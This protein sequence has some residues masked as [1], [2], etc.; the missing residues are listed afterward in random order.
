MMNKKQSPAISIL[1]YALVIPLFAV[2]L[3]FNSCLK[4]DKQHIETDPA[5][6]PEATT[7]ADVSV[8]I[9]DSAFVQTL[10]DAI[11]NELPKDVK[12]Y[13]HVEVMPQF[14]GGDE[15]LRKWLQD[16]IQFPTIA[17][18]KGIQGRVVVRFVVSP[19]GK[20]ENVSIQKSI[21]PACDKEA[22]RVVKTM[23]DWIPGKMGGKGVYVY[24]S[25]PI[26]F[27]STIQ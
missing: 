13:E 22:I 5:T 1:K 4:T 26:N 19:S 20:I 15:A 11:E 6:E 10:N 3:F 25:L 27:K 2:L 9:E 21:D 7:I 8:A 17:A 14:P 24:F 16:N 12:I 23:P 18:E